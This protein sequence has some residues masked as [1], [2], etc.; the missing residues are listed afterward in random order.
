LNAGVLHTLA[1]GAAKYARMSSWEIGEPVFPGAVE[2]DSLTVFANRQL[3]YGTRSDRFD[4]EGQAARRVT[5]IRDNVLQTF[6]ANQRYADY[7]KIA[8][9]GAFGVVELP[10]GKTPTEELLR[11]P[12]VEIV[13]FSWFIPDEITGEFS[14]EIRL[15]YIHE[16]GKRTPLKG[17]SLMG[18]LLQALANVRWSRETG[19]YGDYKGPSTARFANLTVS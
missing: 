10:P 3:P 11:E 9:T 7:L 8:P 5:L 15:G 13:A 2:G 18:N 4:D 1:S 16:G 12:Y 17:G 14:S 6:I 19:F